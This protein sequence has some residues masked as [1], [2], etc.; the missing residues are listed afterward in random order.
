MWIAYHMISSCLNIHLWQWFSTEHNCVLQGA[1]D[2]VWRHFWLQ[3]GEER[4]Y[5]SYLVNRGQ[6]CCLN[7]LQ[8]T[9]YSQQKVMWPSVHNAETEK[10]WSVTPYSAKVA[11]HP[12]PSTFLADAL[13]QWNTC[14]IQFSAYIASRDPFFLFWVELLY[15]NGIFQ[16]AVC[17][18]QLSLLH[19][20]RVAVSQT[21]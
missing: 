8:C 6:G 5:Y 7:T 12:G 9:R 10:L 1:F 17:H 11:F 21:M 19:A 14:K 2:N 16:D 15:K 18:S 4:V 13:N 20:H 3:I